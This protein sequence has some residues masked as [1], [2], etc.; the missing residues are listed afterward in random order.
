[1]LGLAAA[2]RFR[3]TPALAMVLDEPSR[4]RKALADLR[5]SIALETAAALGVVAL[6]AWFGTLAPPAAM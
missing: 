5:R 1:M 3:L 4:Q 2:N 6:V